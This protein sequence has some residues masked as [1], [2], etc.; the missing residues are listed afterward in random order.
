MQFIFRYIILLSNNDIIIKKTLHDSIF[1][2]SILGQHNDAYLF[3]NFERIHQVTLSDNRLFKIDNIEELTNINKKMVLT[4]FL[5]IIN[6]RFFETVEELICRRSVSNQR[7][8]FRNQKKE[9]CFR[10]Y[11][12]NLNIS[13]SLFEK[14]E[15]Y[16][17]NNNHEIQ[18]NE[19]EVAQ[20]ISTHI[21]SFINNYV[22]FCGSIIKSLI[23]TNFNHD[24]FES[25]LQILKSSN[26]DHHQINCNL[27]SSFSKNSSQSQDTINFDSFSENTI[28]LSRRNLMNFF[29]IFFEH[30]HIIVR[31]FDYKNV[32]TF[33]CANKPFKKFYMKKREF[34]NF[35]KNYE[36][37]YAIMEPQFDKLSSNRE[38]LSSIDISPSNFLKI[39]ITNLLTFNQ[40]NRIFINRK[41]ELDLF[42]E[43]ITM[44]KY[45]IIQ[46]NQFQFRFKE[47][48]VC[49]V[50]EIV[51]DS[52]INN[53]FDNDQF[54]FLLTI[55]CWA[56]FEHFSTG[57]RDIFLLYMN[58]NLK[59]IDKNLKFKNLIIFNH[60]KKYNKQILN[61]EEILLDFFSEK[62]HQNKRGFLFQ[63]SCIFIPCINF[64]KYYPN[65]FFLGGTFQTVNI[66]STNYISIYYNN[67]YVMI[68]ISKNNHYFN[69][70]S[71]C[72]NFNKYND[73][74]NC[75]SVKNIFIHN[76]IFNM[77][78]ETS[79]QI[80][81]EQKISEVFYYEIE[82]KRNLHIESCYIYFLNKIR[83]IF[84]S[85]SVK[86]CTISSIDRI[87]E[88]DTDPNE[89][90]SKIIA[91]NFQQCI[92]VNN[93][94]F[95]LKYCEFSMNQCNSNLQLNFRQIFRLKID[96][97]I[98]SVIIN[99]NLSV[100]F[101]CLKSFLQFH[102]VNEDLD[103]T[104]DFFTLYQLKFKQNFF[105]SSNIS[106]FEIK[107]C[108]FEKSTNLFILN[109]FNITTKNLLIEER[110]DD[111][112]VNA[113]IIYGKIIRLEIVTTF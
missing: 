108:I 69:L 86:K 99:D 24:L 63:N 72:K 100:L 94:T 92:F 11:T 104:T 110:F 64:E 84:H 87:I 80:I 47:F 77:I 103:Q 34:I 8:F 38:I 32:F 68:M 17:R 98:G 23:L 101:L 57:I 62:K 45:F 106:Y 107:N 112:C 16:G 36:P 111:F 85:I 15:I 53:S 93:F 49:D 21:F 12:L 43:S 81:G 20:I 6:R 59:K 5:K 44:K 79:L 39:D 3:C 105:L 54:F 61:F 58:E 109:K 48:N 27:N 66:N 29:C 82:K 56:R 70:L 83:L 50:S 35:F 74:G 65:Y 102:T 51:N 10:I 28:F 41:I 33:Y 88:Y 73:V 46:I 18:F 22:D 95:S 75:Y 97:H 2:N 13:H 37:S 90:S 7:I 1:K 40:L 31:D 4:N 55:C 78:F 42:L 25:Q 9:F 91:F 30:Y 52:S 67:N 19:Q 26:L 60:Y 76:T 96:E 14:L 71:D 89:N 113:V